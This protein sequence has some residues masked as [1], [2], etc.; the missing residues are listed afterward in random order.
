VG[1][2]TVINY[3]SQSLEDA[4]RLG[5]V[6]YEKE[7]QSKNEFVL[8]LRS[9][10]ACGAA[11]LL[12]EIPTKSPSTSRSVARR[13]LRGFAQRGIGLPIAASFGENNIKS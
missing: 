1:H 13:N 9:I 6:L 4:A 11:V 2:R 5:K 8:N 10:C 12:P 3:G 7:L